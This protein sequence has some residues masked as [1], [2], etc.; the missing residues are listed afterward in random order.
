MLSLVDA[1]LGR[2]HAVPSSRPLLRVLAA[3]PTAHHALSLPLPLAAAAAAVSVQPRHARALSTVAAVPEA[4]EDFYAGSTVTFGGLGLGAELCGALQQAG[5]SRPAHAQELAVPEILAG[6]DAVLAAETGSG[7]TLAYLAPLVELALRKHR[8][9]AAA[10]A[11][12]A[13][14]Q[15]AEEEGQEAEPW[16][17]QQQ[18]PHRRR[19]HATA[20]LVLCPNAALCEQVLAAAQS[21]R[22]PASGAPLAAAA[23]VSAQSPPLLSLPDVLVTTPGALVSLMDNA[24]AAYGYEWTRAGLPGWARTVVFDEADLLLSGGYGAQMRIIWGALRAGDRLHAARRICLQVGLTEDEFAELP[25][26]LKQVAKLGGAQ[27]L[28]DAGFRPRRQPA[29]GALASRGGSRS[30]SSGGNGARPAA[31]SEEDEEQQQQWLGGLEKEAQPELGV[32]GPSWRRQYVFVAATMPAEGERS[33]GAEIAAR[34]PQAAWLAGRQLHQSKRAVEHAWRR[35]EGAEERAQALQDVVAS[36]PA[37]RAGRGRMLVFAR[38][39]ASAESTAADLAGAGTP[40]LRYHKAVPTA[41]RAAALSRMCSEEGL[42]LVCTD[43]AARG[44]DVPDVSH[45]VQADFAQSAID[46]LHRVGRTARAGKAG[47][48]TSLFTPDVEPLV[49]AIR[50]NIAAG[51]PVEDAFSRK[52]SFR[53]KLRKYGQYVPRGQEGP[54]EPRQARR[55][56]RAARGEERRSRQWR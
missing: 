29:G 8:H 17:Q 14:A 46:F 52:R 26:H 55:E 24:G 18:Q 23:F 7:K 42:V 3:R 16:E 11:A 22:D 43:A 31:G 37:L 38:D 15:H 53:K 5:Y 10:A 12:A 48:V 30:G 21:L 2:L 49:Q 20:A 25:R 45:V 51:Q 56:E 28:L 41:E 27:G 32:H 4:A 44:L 50:D 19:R 13:E 33:V 1:C 47:R 34:F 9:A 39:V 36:D 54:Q 40:V 35:V 6:R